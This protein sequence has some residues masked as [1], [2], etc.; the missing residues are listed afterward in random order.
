MQDKKE[1][2]YQ[3]LKWLWTYLDNEQD[4]N[5]VVEYLKITNQNIIMKATHDPQSGWNGNNV[6]LDGIDLS[7][8]GFCFN[9][10]NLINHVK[11]YPKYKKAIETEEF[12]QYLS[13]KAK[14]KDIEQYTR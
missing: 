8:N 13:L 1:I 3:D 11:N 2:T 10:R 6:Y 7:G 9:G 4:V 5:L 12:K 14:Y